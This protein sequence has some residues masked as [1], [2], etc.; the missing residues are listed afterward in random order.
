M[1]PLREHHVDGMIMIASGSWEQ[2]QPYVDALVQSGHPVVLLQEHVQGPRSCCLRTNDMVGAAAATEYLIEAGHRRIGFLTG[3]VSWPAVEAR[4]QGYAQAL[5]SHRWH[6]P[7]PFIV[8]PEWTRPSALA[9]VGTFLESTERAA[10]PSALL[11]ANDIMAV[12]ALQAAKAAGARVPDDLAIVGFDDLDL[13]CYTDPQL[14]TVNVP[15][16]DMGAYAAQSLFAWLT[17]GTFHKQ[18]V[19]F[20][21]RFIRRGSA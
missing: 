16:Y 12:G 21:T 2:R 8:T 11:C 3:A 6:H 9:A 1:I 19:V 5:P 10:W 7:Q 17:D 13:C 14:T 15:A 20:P 18:D 4:Y